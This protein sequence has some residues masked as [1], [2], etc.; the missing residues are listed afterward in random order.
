MPGRPKFVSY[1][2]EFTGEL[3]AAMGKYEESL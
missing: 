2:E 3:K 1:D